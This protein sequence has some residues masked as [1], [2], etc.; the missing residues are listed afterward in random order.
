MEV[1]DLATDE[2][3][4]EDAFAR[5]EETVRALER[6]DLPLAALVATYEQ[7]MRLTQRCTQ[8]LDEAELKISQITLSSDGTIGTMP[9]DLAS[10][11]ATNDAV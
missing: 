10:K 8:L 1:R 7:G 3:S 11:T 5:L 2:L 4:F 6:G 9:L